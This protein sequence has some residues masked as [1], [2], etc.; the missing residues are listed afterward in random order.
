MQFS[1]SPLTSRINRDLAGMKL[2]VLGNSWNALRKQ[3]YEANLQ[4]NRYFVVR[5]AT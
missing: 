2:L 3:Q 5:Q 4:A 1:P